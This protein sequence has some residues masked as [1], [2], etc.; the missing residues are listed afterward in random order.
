VPYLKKTVL[1]T[2]ERSAA[3]S[4]FALLMTTV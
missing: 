3:G 4:S 2:Q 1:G